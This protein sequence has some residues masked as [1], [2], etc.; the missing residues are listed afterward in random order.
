MKSYPQPCRLEDEQTLKAF[1][2]GLALRPRLP[3]Q[4]FRNLVI[5]L[6]NTAHLEYGDEQAVISI[7]DSAV[8]EGSLRTAKLRLV[9]AWIE[10]HKEEL[11]ADWKLAT[12]GQSVF[13][14]DP[15]E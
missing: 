5:Y 13:K 14:I 10:I 4:E 6:K 2:D 12:S 1:V 8:L 9:E 3:G 11:M 7:P 15:L